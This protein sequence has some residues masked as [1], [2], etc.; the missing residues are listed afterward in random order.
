MREIDGALL[1]KIEQNGPVSRRG[2][3]RPRFSLIICGLM[4]TPP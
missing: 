3:R 1:L 4:P 2:C